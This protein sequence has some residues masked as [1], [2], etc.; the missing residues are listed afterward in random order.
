LPVPG[1]VVTE[2]ALFHFDRMLRRFLLLGASAEDSVV[3]LSK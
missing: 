1:E 2:L 3:A